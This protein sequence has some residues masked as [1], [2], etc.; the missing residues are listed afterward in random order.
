MFNICYYWISL[1]FLFVGVNGHKKTFLHSFFMS[2][3][4]VRLQIF[5]LK[6]ILLLLL[7]VI[8]LKGEKKEK[9]SSYLVHFPIAHNI[10]GWTKWN[11]I[12]NSHVG[13]SEPRVTA[14]TACLPGCALA[15]SWV[16]NKAR[17]PIRALWYEMGC[18]TQQL[19]HIFLL[20]ICMSPV[21]WAASCVRQLSPLVCEVVVR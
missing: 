4:L 7:L 17:T 8:Y 20:V 9:A 12:G 3:L 16:G 15:E 18:T 1:V 14:I 13:G 5:S 10:Q 6:K 2:W 11:W 21:N 19:N